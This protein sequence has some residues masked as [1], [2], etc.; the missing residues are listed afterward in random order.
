LF[1]SDAITYLMHVQFS[2][3][4]KEDAAL[5]FVKPLPRRAL[6]EVQN[7]PGVIH[8][9]GLRMVPVRI[10]HGPKTETSAMIG[11]DPIRHL[12]ALLD[13][14]LKPIQIPP[15]G[16]VMSQTLARKL[17]IKTQDQI[18]LEVLEGSRP[19]GVFP[20]AE[21]VDDFLGMFLYTQTDT[22]HRLMKEGAKINSVLVKT[23]GEQ[24]QKLYTEL[25]NY[26]TI[27]SVSFKTAALKTFNE[28]TAK[29]MLVFATILTIFSI[30]IAFGIVYNS[31]RI[32]LSERNWEFASLQVL[33]FNNFEVFRMLMGEILTLCL[34]ALP[35]GWALGY[36]LTK[37]LVDYMA[38]EELAIPMKIEMSTFTYSALALVGSV[39]ISG[40]VL[41]QK[42]KSLNF[43]EALK[44]RG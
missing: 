33:G 16:I 4:Q 25:K 1:W 8:A 41:W 32:T 43:N 20:I 36:Y 14:N 24:S 31:M 44:T 27:S 11:V 38:P 35:L 26:P 29:F 5:F 12:R 10:Y 9:E 42:I 19:K 22:L 15:D 28:T 6:H 18:A 23:D 17:K 7:L 34:V 30:I 3:I 39:I 40:W 37:I 13:T 2:L 21:V